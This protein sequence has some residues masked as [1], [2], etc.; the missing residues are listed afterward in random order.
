[1]LWASKNNSGFAT[2]C[3]CFMKWPPVKKGTAAMAG[4]SLIRTIFLGVTEPCGFGSGSRYP[5]SRRRPQTLAWPDKRPTAALDLQ[6]CSR[7]SAQSS[8]WMRPAPAIHEGACRRGAPALVECPCAALRPLAS[9]PILPR[10]PKRCFVISVGIVSD[11]LKFFGQVRRKRAGNVPVEKIDSF[12]AQ[13][14]RCRADNL[15]CDDSFFKGLMEVV[16]KL[17]VSCG[18]HD[19]PA[20]T[21]ALKRQTGILGSHSAVHLVWIMEF[22]FWAGLFCAHVWLG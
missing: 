7:V 3:P 16:E 9:L 19:Q 12:R 21:Y 5:A 8:R 18:I 17:F 4:C 22:H 13:H 20:D 6:G 15:L 11:V 1:M 2:H 10:D 14:F